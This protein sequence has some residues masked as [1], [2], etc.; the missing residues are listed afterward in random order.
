MHKINGRILL[1]ITCEISSL[2]VSEKRRKRALKVAFFHNR[3]IRLK[4]IKVNWRK[5]KR[6]KGSFWVCNVACEISTLF[7]SFVGSTIFVGCGYF[8]LSQV[9]DLIYLENA[10][11]LRNA[12]T[13]RL[14]NF[15]KYGAKFNLR[16]KGHSFFYVR[17]CQTITT[18]LLLWYWR[19]SF[20]KS[21]RFSTSFRI[22]R[23][24]DSPLCLKS[25]PYVLPNWTH[26]SVL[27]TNFN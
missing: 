5:W 12:T 18:T 27:P 19:D 15:R 4:P 13:T 24:N 14:T 9:C 23:L 7:S 3:T 11:W 6:R 2:F 21:G 22:N 26:V 8:N 16:K 1:S 20:E 10:I 17:K 25:I